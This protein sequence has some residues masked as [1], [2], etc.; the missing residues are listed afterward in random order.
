MFDPNYLEEIKVAC[1]ELES[2]CNKVGLQKTLP[3]PS[4][5][6]S[7]SPEGTTLW[8]SGYASLLLWP[9]TAS[10]AETINIEAARAQSWFDEVLTNRE[11]NTS[12]NLIDGYLILAL[13]SPPED[14]A[15]EEVRRLEISA[16]V[17]RKHI[18]WQDNTSLNEETQKKWLRLADITVL[19]LPDVTNAVVEGLY[20]PN[21]D[22]EAQ[23]VWDDLVT[24]GV[25]GTVQQDEKR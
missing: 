25:T 17:C 19:G 22:S 18:I 23:A 8:S 7:Q 3:L 16:Q 21:I 6:H 15:K 1:V 13:P 4:V 12:R 20:W 24:L 2:L 9:S 10:D 5:E 11:N 14:T